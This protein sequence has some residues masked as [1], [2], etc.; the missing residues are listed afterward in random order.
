LSIVIVICVFIA[1]FYTFYYII[2]I[3][4]SIGIY[5]GILTIS[6]HYNITLSQSLKLG[7]STLPTLGIA[8]DIVY[9]MIPISVMMFAIAILWMFSRL[10]SKWSVSAIIILSAIYVMLVHLLESNFNFNGFAESFMVPYIINLLILALSVYSLIAILYGSDS[11]FEIEINPLTP[12]SNMAI[13]SNKLMRHLKG[14]LR[15]L[16]SHFDNT[17]FDNLS[18]LILR[19]MNKYTSIYILTYLE[20]NSRGFGRGYTDFKNELQNKN[21]KFEL[22]IMG[23]EDF[24]RQHER[25]MMDSNT[26]YKIPP[27]NI[28]NRKSE[29]I[30]SLNHDEAFR[31]FNEIWNRSKSYENFSKG[32]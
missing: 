16:D 12:Y 22:R 19:N 1:L 10:Y 9:I 11:D 13:I 27:I 24:S 25:I 3:S 21:I 8:L 32:S 31:R 14:D 29:H 6:E 17:S 20:E 7:L 28:I 18:R 30:V 4:R 5:E 15:I 26:A 23:R 2:D